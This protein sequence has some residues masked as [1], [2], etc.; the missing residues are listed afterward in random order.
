[1]LDAWTFHPAP[2]GA[3]GR[4]NVHA[5]LLVD[6]YRH[7]HRNIAA[8][9]FISGHRAGV[10]SAPADDAMRTR[11]S[12]NDVANKGISHHEPLLAPT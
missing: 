4:R 6:G 5:Q 11:Q 8:F 7:Q 3:A 12:S 9:A 2:R 10:C 1:M